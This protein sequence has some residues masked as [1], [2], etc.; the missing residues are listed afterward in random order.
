M[1]EDLRGGVGCAHESQPQMGGLVYLL[2][3]LHIADK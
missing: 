2:A 3:Y 1:C